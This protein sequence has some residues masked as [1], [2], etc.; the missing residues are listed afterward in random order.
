MKKKNKLSKTSKLWGGR[1][2]KSIAPE[3][4]DFSESISY[5][6]TLAEFDIIQSIAH[7]KTLNKAKLISTNEAKTLIKGLHKIE[8]LRKVNKLDLSISNEDIHTS[9]EKKLTELVGDVGKKLHTARSRNDQ[10]TTDVRLYLKNEIKRTI[11]NLK[12][13]TQTI[14]QIST[15]EAATLMPGYT[16][17]Q[18]A[19]PITLGHHLNAY[20]FMFLRDLKRLENNL[21]STDYLPLGSG[22]LAGSNHSLDRN[23][24]SKTLFFKQITQNSL[25]AVSDRDMIAE[26]LFHSALIQMHLSRLSE[27]LILWASTEFK[28]IEIDDAYATGSSLMP[29]K[30]NPDVAELIRG[31]TGRMYGNLIGMLTVLKALPMSYNRDLQEDKEF[32]FDSV[33]TVQTSLSL[34]N[35]LLQNI[36]FNRQIM[37]H[38]I[39]SD[40]TILATDLADILVKQGVAFRKTHEIVGLVVQYALDQG[41]RLQDLNDDEYQAFSQYFPK[42]TAKLLSPKQSVYNK[43]TIGS[44]NPNE[45]KRQ[46][47][48]ILKNI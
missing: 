45:V 15:K 3:L 40:P 19:M 23:L 47:K 37:F 25:D 12:K 38:A 34:M 41:K 22:A 1:F 46:S 7:V 8:D 29:Q 21:I 44:P 48:Y 43:K 32:L 6:H 18:R 10:V 33:K 28:F 42:N 5:D 35:S 14:A 39:N 13:I 27:D 17:L 9:I 31:K 20:A 16:H 30:K 2:K 11:V 36:H 4:L 24:T 26:F